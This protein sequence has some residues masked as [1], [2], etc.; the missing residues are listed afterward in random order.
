MRV[1][2]AL[3]TN[4][5]FPGAKT[6]ADMAATLES[7][8]F[9]GLWVADHIV[10]PSEFSS[11]YPF[12]ADGRVTWPSDSPWF[13]AVVALSAASA[14][15]RHIELGIGVLVLALRHP[16]V[17]AKQLASLDVISG[18]RLAVGVGA[19]WLREEFDALGV[20]FETRG[21][22][23]DEWMTILRQC[24]TGHPAA[25]NGKHYVLPPGVICQPSPKRK[26]DILV[27]GVTRAARQRAAVSG[28]G[29]L[30]I[31]RAA[32]L[33]PEDIASDVAEIRAAAQKVGRN[34]D[35]LRM[36]LR[37]IECQN[38]E[39]RVAAVLPDLEDA[40]V[41]DVVVDSSWEPGG[42][43]RTCDLLRNALR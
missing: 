27:G 3:P 22:R 9:D 24:W 33:D 17:V 1:A 43:E 14:V 18:G 26:V 32:E 8:G 7:A 5:E 4:G 25:I 40:G 42:P 31:C 23:L 37:I 10:M 41:T 15:T 35:S 12:A 11:R 30:A 29:W 16:V 36:V 13:D 21:S 2:A 28:D 34:P 19:G 6:I 20:P 39:Q 38:R